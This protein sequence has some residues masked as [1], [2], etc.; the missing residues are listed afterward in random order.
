LNNLVKLRK[1]FL[2]L[3]HFNKRVRPHPP[4][5]SPFHGEGEIGG[6]VKTT[7]VLLCSI[8]PMDSAV[9]H[10]LMHYQFLDKF[11]IFCSMRAL[12]KLNRE[13]LLE[14]PAFGGT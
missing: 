4:S 14:C 1:I 13:V 6:E 12:K 5:P 7:I 8:T 11:C 3:L 2:V 9:R 10:K